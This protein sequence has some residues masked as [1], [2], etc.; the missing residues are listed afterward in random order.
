M[1]R[2][3]FIGS[4]LAPVF[5]SQKS[6]AGIF[7]APEF[8]APSPDHLFFDERFSRAQPLATGLAG[9]EKAQKLHA[10]RGD[11]TPVWNSWLKQASRDDSLVIQGVTSESFVFCLEHLLRM[12]HA[13]ELSVQRLDRDL[14]AWSLTAHNKQNKNRRPA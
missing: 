5:L 14:L 11:I 9:W 10:V 12:S 13:L 4:S 7:S 6:L 2:R 3:N 8:T 1:K